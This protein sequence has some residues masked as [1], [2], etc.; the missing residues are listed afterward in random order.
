M[1]VFGVLLSK[2]VLYFDDSVTCDPMSTIR[3][4]APRTT[5]EIED[6]QKSDWTWIRIMTFWG[7]E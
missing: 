2:I 4:K 3:L 7:N 5:F 1:D 6:F